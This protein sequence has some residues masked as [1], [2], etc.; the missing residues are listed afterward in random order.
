MTPFDRLCNPKIRRD[1]SIRASLRARFRGADNN[2]DRATRVSTPQEEQGF[3][4]P[5]ETEN[6]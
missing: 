5:L 2:N 3:I 4:R 6:P 1:V